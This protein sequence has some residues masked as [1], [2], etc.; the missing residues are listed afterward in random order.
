[1]SAFVY[2][3]PA[4]E[5]VFEDYTVSVNG[6]PAA[7]YTARVSAIPFNRS[8]PGYQRPLEQTEIA[9]VLSL[10][11]TEPVRIEIRWGSPVTEAIVRPVSKG[12]PVKIDGDTVSFVIEKPG[13]YSAEVNGRHQN[14]HIFANEPEQAVDPAAF[15]YYFAPGVYE[16]GDLVLYSG[17]SVYIAAGAVVH[18]GIQAYDAENIR[19][20][21]RG[22]LDYS[23]MERSDPL[24]WEKDGLMIFARCRN[25]VLE[26]ITLR[27]A[28][29]WTVT[30]FNCVGL[31][32]R[33]V[34][35]VGMWRYNSDGFD[36]VN[37]QNV[38][39]DG[40]FLRNYDDVIVFKGLRIKDPDGG[41]P[42]YEHM[43]LCN[44][45]VENC[46][47][48]CDWGGALEIGAETVADRYT[49]MVYRNCD[50]L[51][52][53]HGALRIQSGDR[54]HISNVL[55]EDIRVEFSKHDQGHKL[56]LS[57]EDIFVPPE[58]WHWY[59]IR[60]WIY[61][62]RWSDDG[63]LGNVH[64]ITYRNIAAYTDDEALVPEISLKGVDKDHRF[65]NITIE[66]VSLNGK[67]FDPPVNA[68][69]NNGLVT[70]NG[71]VVPEIG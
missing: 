46:V 42:P 50:V 8:W 52:S 16:V 54:A 43:D 69:T 33:N 24:R 21:G 34:K 12:I 58:N 66:N 48:W 11:M 5:P 27:D 68:N 25:V 7:L 56:Q 32:Y 4:G 63:I 2:P 57:D 6:T 41:R 14:L 64:D 36:F 67:P 71:R 10:D 47:L 13:Q 62:N 29:W 60:G 37:C 55:Y 49:N 51:R 9:P 39:V 44:Y 28:S 35:A 38:H 31:L 20:C 45:L 53:D 30:A 3:V 65:H 18:G 22:I 15:T 17:E 23:K 70:L 1:M 61:C 59:L 26:G 19:I 40:C